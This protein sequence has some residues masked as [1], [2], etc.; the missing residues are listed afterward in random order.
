MVN[1]DFLDGKRHTTSTYNYIDK[2]IRNQY[3]MKSFFKLKLFMIK[4]TKKI[5][6]PIRAKQ[7]MC[8]GRI[9]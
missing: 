8:H 5:I 9:D 6:K 1:C 2:L 7:A 3:I 4:M